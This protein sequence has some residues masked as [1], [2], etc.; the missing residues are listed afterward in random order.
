M[1]NYSKNPYKKVKHAPWGKYEQVLFNQ[2]GTIK[3]VHVKKGEKI[4]LQM[5]ATRDE[6][7][8]VLAGSPTIQ[9]GPPDDIQ[10]YSSKK[11]DEFFIPKN[12]AHQ[13]SA[14]KGKVLLLAV[15]YGKFNL[16]DK[17]RIHDEYGR[18]KK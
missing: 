7:W 16:D 10:S 14:L 4:S 6:Y 5:H 12:T 15:S 1:T 3:L 18:H 13:A 11:G 2:L 9:L 17:V 8:K